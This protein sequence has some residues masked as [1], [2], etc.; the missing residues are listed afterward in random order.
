MV[1]S[2]GGDL[3][4]GDHN[5]GPSEYSSSPPPQHHRGFT[6]ESVLSEWRRRDGGEPSGFVYSAIEF[7]SLTMLVLFTF[8][9]TWRCLGESYSWH[10]MH[11]PL[12]GQGAEPLAGVP[13]PGEQAVVGGQSP[14]RGLGQRPKT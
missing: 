14:S 6:F 5:L 13:L 7:D 3:R 1:A 10:N 12:R 8:G 4:G 11:R 9:I 2:C